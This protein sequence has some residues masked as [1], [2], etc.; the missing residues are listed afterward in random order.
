MLY[1]EENQDLINQYNLMQA[2]TLL[3]VSDSGDVKVIAGAPS[4]FKEVS[5]LMS[6]ARK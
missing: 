1:A 5:N 4:V 6:A 3:E 2:P